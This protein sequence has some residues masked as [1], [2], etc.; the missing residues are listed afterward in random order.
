M[1]ET[2]STSSR[3]R[4]AW[5]AGLLLLCLF[6]LVLGVFGAAYFQRHA[7]AAPQVARNQPP[8]LPAPRPIA[9]APAAAAPPVASPAPENSLAA[10]AVPPHES[11][12]VAAAPAAP[13]T[14]IAPP[15]LS[16]PS[17]ATAQNLARIEPTAAPADVAAAA[18]RYW[19]EFGAYEAAFFAN[20]L[21]QSL[22]TLGIAAKVT[23]APG[24]HGRRYL[25]VRS[26]DDSDRAAAVAQL[27]KAEAALHI[28]PLL[29]R[30]AAVSPR[31]T[32]T[33]GAAP[34]GNHWV[35]F[36]AFHSHAGADTTLANLHKNDIQATVIKINSI[37]DGPLYLVRVAGLADRAQAT[38]IAQQGAAALHSHDVL[39]GES[40]PAHATSTSG[41]P[42]GPLAR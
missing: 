29:H 42:E 16:S 18:P 5:G 4:R 12:P 22:G 13:R 3:S 23:P 1:D 20:R 35:Q 37:S 11:A 8:P 19:V 39:I 15:P 31:A 10:Q 27:G 32:R 34:R 6:A 9:P 33:A 41:L 28:V 17:A 14:A 26:S 21:K 2:Q 24:A 7:P 30:V 25:R 36:G 40:V 38:Q